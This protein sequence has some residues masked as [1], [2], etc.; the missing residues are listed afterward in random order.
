MKYKICLI[1]PYFGKLPNYFQLWLNSCKHN[2]D[3]DFLIYTDDKTK[4]EYPKNVILKYTTFDEIKKRIQQ[5]YDFP[6]ALKN[7]YKLCDY[8]VAYGEIFS[9]DIEK[10]DFWGHCDLDLIWGDIRMFITDE[11]LDNYEKILPRGHF[12]IY[13]NTKEI[14]SRYKNEVKDVISYKEVF[15]SNHS[16]AFDEWNGLYKIYKK[17]NY[18]LYEDEICADISVKYNILNINSTKENSIFTWNVENEK[19]KIYSYTYKNKIVKKEYMYIHLQKR[20]MTVTMPLTQYKDEYIIVP[21]EFVPKDLQAIN[22]KLIKKYTKIKLIRK[23]Y[24][25]MKIKNLLQKIKK[26]RKG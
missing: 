11:I 25:K 22:K 5:N 15:T 19:S 13:K 7:A 16:F 26:R 14:N 21:N 20:N 10:Y 4:Y 24:M 23:E 1:I 9:K 18:K 8:K 3:I 2:P 17:Q 12:S 6:I